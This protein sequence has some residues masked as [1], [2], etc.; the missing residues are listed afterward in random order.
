MAINS[1]TLSSQPPLLR[2]LAWCGHEWQDLMH[3]SAT[4]PLGKVCEAIIK[5]APGLFLS[6]ATLFAGLL[7]I[8]G[9]YLS[10]SMDLAH[11]FT[12]LP[13]FRGQMMELGIPNVSEEQIADGVIEYLPQSAFSSVGVF[14][15]NHRFENAV[16]PTPIKDIRLHVS[17][18][19][20]CNALLDYL[21]RALQLSTSF[22]ASD[23]LDFILGN[24]QSQKTRAAVQQFI[25]SYK[26][27]DLYISSTLDKIE[28]SCRLA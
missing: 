21:I 15:F 28:L 7:A 25:Q 4:S 2:P 8:G 10:S 24:P 27:V 19:T 14:S 16:R 18:Y 13:R 1:L 5:L 22:Q 26:T 3:I 23:V 11:T 9:Y 12:P 17:E 20:P 6:L